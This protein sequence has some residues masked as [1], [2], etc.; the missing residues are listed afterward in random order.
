M[1]MAK[2]PK[3][4]QK[5]IIR[6]LLFN[7]VP[8][9]V[10]GYMILKENSFF[11]PNKIWDLHLT[12]TIYQTMDYSQYNIPCPCP[13]KVSHPHPLRGIEEVEDVSQVQCL[14]YPS[15]VYNM[16]WGKICRSTF[17]YLCLCLLSSSSPHLSKRNFLC[18]LTLIAFRWSW[19]IFLYFSL[20]SVGRKERSDVPAR[21]W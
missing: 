9:E 14:G 3:Q 12:T 5:R 16:L 2:T 7:P 20:E 18:T 11:T 19:M 10:C 15:L 17:L 8:Y 1:Q 21:R 4:Q 6:Q 13:E